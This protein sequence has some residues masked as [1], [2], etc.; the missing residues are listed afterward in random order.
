LVTKLFEGITLPGT[1]YGSVAK[2]SP[3]AMKSIHEQENQELI[4]E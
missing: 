1:K 3:R 4:Y 2:N